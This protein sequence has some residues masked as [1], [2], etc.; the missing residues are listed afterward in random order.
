M[1]VQN[2]DHRLDRRLNPMINILIKMMSISISC[3]S[4]V[5][6]LSYTY[7]DNFVCAVAMNICLNDVCIFISGYGNVNRSFEQSF[8]LPFILQT[9]NDNAV[10]SN[11]NDNNCNHQRWRC[12]SPRPRP[13]A[14]D[15]GRV[16]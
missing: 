1:N 14:G 12:S 5:G 8:I 16:I 2:T 11:D 13:E 3:M 9:S 4:M 10:N 7:V 6:I 15:A